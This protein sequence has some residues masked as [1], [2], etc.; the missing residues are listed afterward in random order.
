M[1]KQRPFNERVFL[2]SKIKELEEQLSRANKRIEQLEEA[3]NIE[4]EDN[5]DEPEIIIDRTIF[6]A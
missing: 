6:P 2:K 4:V 3:L 1:E 5:K